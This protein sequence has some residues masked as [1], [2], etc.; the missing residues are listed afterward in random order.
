MFLFRPLTLAAL[1]LGGWLGMQVEQF[2]AG[3]RCADA[4]GSLDARGVCR[5]APRQ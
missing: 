1:L 5:G 4:R 2:L 3:G